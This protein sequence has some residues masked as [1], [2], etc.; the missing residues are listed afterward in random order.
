MWKDP[1]VE[2]IREIR[3][4]L[5]EKFDGDLAAMFEDLRKREQESGREFVTFTDRPANPIVVPMPN[6]TAP[7]DNSA[8]SPI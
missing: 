6:A 2:E 5:T 4:Q 3:H 8:N 1:I 7:T